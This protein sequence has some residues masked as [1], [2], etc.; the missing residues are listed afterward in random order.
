MVQEITKVIVA[1]ALAAAGS[2]YAKGDYLGS[3]FW[4]GVA[5]VTAFGG[6]FTSAGMTSGGHAGGAS[7]GSNAPQTINLVPMAAG[8]PEE[9]ISIVVH[10]WVGSEDALASVVAKRLGR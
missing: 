3:L 8:K 5:G 9:R 10:G 7:G 2:A 4:L 6:A 1:W